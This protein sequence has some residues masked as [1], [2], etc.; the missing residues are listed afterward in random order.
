MSE[1][2]QTATLDEEALH[3]ASL[4]LQGHFWR[5]GSMYGI[6][7]CEE[8]ARI[9]IVAY[10]RSTPFATVDQHEEAWAKIHD[11]LA[12]GYWTLAREIFD[13]AVSGAALTT[14]ERA[15]LE[16][17]RSQP[18]YWAQN[19]GDVLEDSDRYRWFRDECGL[20]R[21]AEIVEAAEGVADMLDHHIDKG[22]CGL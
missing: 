15:E 21:Q 6:K 8:I 14:D 19:N 3:R 5:E 4:E 10:G 1:R 20:D 22:R 16:R 2:E 17:L 18:Y 11:L 9:A 13:Q 12:A 7:A